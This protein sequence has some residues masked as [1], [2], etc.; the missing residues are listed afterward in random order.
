[1]IA[2]EASRWR[3]TFPRERRTSPAP[4]LTVGFLHG[5][6]QS[7]AMWWRLKRRRHRVGRVQVARQ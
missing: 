7:L 6:L 3:H 4:G 2:E 1:M 5:R